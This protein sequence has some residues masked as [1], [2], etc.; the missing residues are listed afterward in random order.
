[1]TILRWHSSLN[2]FYC[3]KL[4]QDLE[5]KLVTTIKK[6][7][8]HQTATE[9]DLKALLFIHLCFEY[10]PFPSLCLAFVD[11]SFRIW[12]NPTKM[13]EFWASQIQDKSYR[14]KYFF[15]FFPILIN[16]ESRLFFT[17]GGG[18]PVTNAYLRA[19]VKVSVFEN[20]QLTLGGGIS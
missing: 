9:D 8:I 2:I 17:V 14:W 20:G 6:K 13:V 7:M 18:S 1:M 4:D 11:N 12:N 5:F 3:K 10:D 15:V 19:K 16:S